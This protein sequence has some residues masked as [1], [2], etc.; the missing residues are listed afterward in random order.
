[1]FRVYAIDRVWQTET[2][3]GDAPDRKKFSPKITSIYAL[4]INYHQ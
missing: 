4:V 2:G 3:L 1:M